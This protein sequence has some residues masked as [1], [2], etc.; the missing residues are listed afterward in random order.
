MQDSVLEELVSIPGVSG[1]EYLIDY[2][3]EG[4]LREFGVRDY[5]QDRMGNLILRVP[6]TRAAEPPNTITSAPI[7]LFAAHKDTIGFMVR[8][9]L[10]DGMLEVIGVGIRTLKKNT[11]TPVVVY[12]TNYQYSGTVF[13]PKKKKEKRILVN[14]G[15]TSEAEVHERGIKIGDPVAYVPQY[16]RDENSVKT[17]YLDDRLGCF[18]LLELLERVLQEPNSYQGIDLYFVFTAKEELGSLGAATLAASVRP[19]VAFVIDVTWEEGPI[20][21]GAGPVLTLLDG[22]TILSVVERDYITEVAREND[23]PLQFEVLNAGSSDAAKIQLHGEGV[24]TVCILPPTRYPHTA[25]EVGNMNDVHNTT[26]LLWLI[27]QNLPAFL[28]LRP[29]PGYANKT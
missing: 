8:A 4:K 23:I 3:L 9:I 14:L 28:E 1:N 24:K 13:C 7:C 5:K 21:L 22:G 10:P 20:K 12:S 2:F 25:M 27:S 6:S 17:A 18:I 19:D 15:C 26:R 11:E 16:Q 29:A